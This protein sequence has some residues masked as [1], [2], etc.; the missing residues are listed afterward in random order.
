V[1]GQVQVTDAS[2]NVTAA[3]FVSP[4]PTILPPAPSPPS[5]KPPMNFSVPGN[6]AITAAIP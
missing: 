3:S 2:G 4:T 5:R 1:S 6:I